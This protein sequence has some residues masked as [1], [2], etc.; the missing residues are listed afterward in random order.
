MK[1]QIFIIFS[2]FII[3]CHTTNNGFYYKTKKGET[4]DQLSRKFGINKETIL[5]DNY[6]SEDYKLKSGETIFIHAGYQKVKKDKKEDILPNKKI[7]ESPIKT[8]KPN[9]LS[10]SKNKVI[11]KFLWPAKGKLLRYFGVYDGLFSEGI[12]IQLPIGS[13]VNATASGNVIFAKKH[14]MYGN[15]III[16]HNYIFISIYA[17]LK[18]IYVN[19]GQSVTS[20]DTI[21]LSGS[22]MEDDSEMLHFEIRKSSK[23]VDPLEYL[24]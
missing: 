11:T 5:I 6:L 12:D 1:L 23:P 24:K 17:N 10:T 14:G 13:D 9:N 20:G 21:A 3:S 18:E 16:Q 2:F 8:I 22:K 19:E 4:I 15:T 7:T